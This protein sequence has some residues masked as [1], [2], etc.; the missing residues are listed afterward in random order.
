MKKEI[1]T[2]EFVKQVFERFPRWREFKFD[3]EIIHKC[4]YRAREEHPQELGEMRFRMNMSFPWSDEV[5][6]CIQTLGSCDLFNVL[7]PYL[8]T[9]IIPDRMKKGPNESGVDDKIIDETSKQLQ[10]DLELKQ[11]KESK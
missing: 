3:N 2:Y 6:H 4:F 5:E 10:E 9:F 8:R 11:G 7:G 1:D